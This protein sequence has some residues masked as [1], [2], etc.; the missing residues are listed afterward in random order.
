M[1]VDIWNS[2]R[3][4]APTIALEK[5]VDIRTDMTLM[6]LASIKTSSGYSVGVRAGDKLKAAIDLL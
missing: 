1:T 3:Y 5:G 4:T 6:D 2:T